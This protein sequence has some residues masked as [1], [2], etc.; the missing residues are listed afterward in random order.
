VA[1]RPNIL[2]IMSDQHNAAV[3]GCAG[4]RYVRTPNLDALAG[5]GVRLT[6]MYT[7]CPLCLPARMSF[8]TAREPGDLGILD[9]G[10]WLASDMPTFAHGFAAA[11]YEAVLCGRMHFEGPDQFHGF[12]KR[13]LGDCQHGALAPQLQTPGFNKA[14]GQ[15]KYGV[16]I[17]GCGRT[18]YEAFDEAV[19]DTACQ[20]LRGRG[21]ERPYCLVVGMMLP[22][23]PLICQK[24]LL[25]YYLDVLPAPQPPSKEYLKRVT[26]DG[27]TTTRKCQCQ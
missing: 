23:N 25:D 16:E 11:G 5:G 9:N 12:E 13:L 1:S 3:L 8:M 24:Q 17:A 15:T 14:N 7:P 2:L 27:Q 6:N 26:T 4:D 22:H 19:T 10:T 21:D 18:G 20:Y